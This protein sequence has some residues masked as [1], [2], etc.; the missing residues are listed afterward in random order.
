MCAIQ[1]FSRY[2]HHIIFFIKTL[3]L[4]KKYTVSWV[5]ITM[6]WDRG[7]SSGNLQISNWT[8][9]SLKHLLIC[10]LNILSSIGPTEHSGCSFN[11]AYLEVGPKNYPKIKNTMYWKKI[12]FFFSKRYYP[13]WANILKT[14]SIPD[15][16]M[17][18]L[19]G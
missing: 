13:M 8:P 7:G 14:N 3:L 4:Q 17:H 2:G 15:F 10:E 6:V 18:I 5:S 1:C 12:F 16:P 11:V 19:Q 9:N